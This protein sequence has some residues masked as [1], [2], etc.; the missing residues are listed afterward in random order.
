MTS[1]PNPKPMTTD[2]LWGVWCLTE[3]RWCDGTIG[4]LAHAYRELPHWRSGERQD[5][6]PRLARTFNYDVRRAWHAEVQQLQQQLDAARTSLAA[7][8]AKVAKLEAR[9]HQLADQRDDVKIDAEDATA[10]RIA[11]W[12]QTR[13]V[14]VPHAVRADERTVQMLATAIERGDWRPR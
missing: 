6:E 13:A 5:I 12:L 8:E 3:D 2:G 14:P 11:E 1:S 4:T 9:T 7:A 10:K